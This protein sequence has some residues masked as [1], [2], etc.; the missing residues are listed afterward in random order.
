[1]YKYLFISQ[2]EPVIYE[3]Y[4]VNNVNILKVW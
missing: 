2:F 1:M 4:V 3:V